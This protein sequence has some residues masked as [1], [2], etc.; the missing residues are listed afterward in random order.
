M[1]SLANAMFVV[2][3]GL[4]MLGLSATPA[5]FGGD[6]SVPLLVISFGWGVFLALVALSRLGSAAEVWRRLRSGLRG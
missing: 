2:L 4:V 6:L 5:L 3:S 1:A